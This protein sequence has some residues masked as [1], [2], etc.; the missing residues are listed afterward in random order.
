MAKKIDGTLY[1][2]MFLNGVVNLENN[3]VEI[4]ELNV[5]PVPDGDTGTNMSMTM[6]AGYDQVRSKDTKSV[7]EMSKE[8]SRG[9]LMGARGNSGVIL[10]QLFRGIFKGISDH[11]KKSIDVEQFK[12]ALVV[13]YETAY[14]AVMNP[15]EGTILTVA[16]E[17]AVMA[18]LTP[19]KTIEETLDI[20]LQ[21]AHASLQR[22]PELLPVL[23]EAGVV[24]SGAA[25]LIKVFEGMR[26]LFAG[27]IHKLSDDARVND[28]K[29]LF[30]HTDFN[31][32]IEDIKFQ[33][34]T[35]FIVEIKDFKSFRE[36]VLKDRLI[37]L[38]DSLV[39]VQDDEIL[40]V[41]IH[42]NDPG[43]AI[44]I[45]LEY[46]Q[47]ITVKIENMIKQAIEMGAISDQPVGEPKEL[48]VISVSS[49]EGI[50]DTFMELGVDFVIEG[51]QTMNPSAEDFL[52]AIKKVN[53]KNIIIIPNNSNV[54]LSAEQAASL[55]EEKNV[56]VIKAKTI[57][58]GYAAMINYNAGGTV[59]DNV[60]NMSA[61]IVNAKAGE[62]TYSIRDT[63]INGVSIKNGDFM[64][65]TGGNIITSQ[66]HRV[67]TTK[68]LLENLVDGDS[69]VVTLFY[70]V[71]VEEE[72]V[73]GISKYIENKYEDAE[74]QVIKGN[75][76]IYS[77]IICVE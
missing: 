21:E 17:A 76:E 36:Q 4:D 75:Q 65:I 11:D 38:G 64:G 37:P 13:G 24:D 77:Y 6:M 28:N 34:C 63:E 7:V 47:L 48:G 26:D 42:T 57:G 68:T 18:K 72:E 1:K 23:K 27:K 45:S 22:T 35:E 25:G 50:R 33:Y 10:S 66:E 16:R 29:E 30:P 44:S 59:N 73:D 69:E 14:K 41:H 74:V 46:G 51:G 61:A 40:K 56:Q 12:D 58:H 3:K 20:Y 2:K 43:N 67:E 55:E 54:I 19:S 31:I 32:K 62:V 71:D 60:A 5:F 49:G 52:N 15:T 8:I 70:G 39:V 9:L 53:A